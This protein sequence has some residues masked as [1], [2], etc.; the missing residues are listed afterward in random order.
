MAVMGCDIIRGHGCYVPWTTN[1]AVTP[2]TQLEPNITN[3]SSHENPRHTA[4]KRK[5]QIERGQAD[6]RGFR[7]RMTK[8]KSCL[9]YSHIV[10]SKASF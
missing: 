3:P 4:S 7:L 10:I 9:T 8:N 6:V 5:S 2:G 1:A